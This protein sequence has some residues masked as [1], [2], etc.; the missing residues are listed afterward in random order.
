MI[1]PMSREHLSD[2]ARLHCSSL[3]GLLRQLGEPAVLAYYRG[4]LQSPQFVAFV[5]LDDGAVAGFVA[6]SIQPDRMKSAVLLA[7]PLGVLV[8]VLFGALRHP[9]SLGWLALSLRGPDN[10][11]YDARVP[12]LTYLATVERHRRHG[13]GRRLVGAFSAAMRERSVV[14]YEL[15]VEEGNRAATDFYERVGFKPIGRYQE[16]GTRY[17]RYRTDVRV[18]PVARALD[19]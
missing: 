5:H 11:A 4:A 15:S 14:A 19:P 3:G 16:F 6:G 17:I 13:I 18:A 2:V 10:G 8:G 1:V 7:N 9:W 12:E